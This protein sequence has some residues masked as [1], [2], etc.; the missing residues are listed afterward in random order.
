MDR[1]ARDAR[2]ARWKSVTAL[3]GERALHLQRLFIFNGFSSSRLLLAPR[4]FQIHRQHK[5]DKNHEE[6]GR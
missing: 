5:R 4:R 2:R 1:A 6:N 3:S